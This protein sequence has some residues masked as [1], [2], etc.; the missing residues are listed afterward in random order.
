M[1]NSSKKIRH[2]AM[3][4]AGRACGYSFLHSNRVYDHTITIYTKEHKK[5][6]VNG[7]HTYWRDRR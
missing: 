7:K 3:L 5:Y 6:Y 4:R 2:V 1:D